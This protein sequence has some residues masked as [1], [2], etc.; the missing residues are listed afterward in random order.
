[1]V[2]AKPHH[3]IGLFPENSAIKENKNIQFRD[4]LPANNLTLFYT[5]LLCS[6]IFYLSK[7]CELTQHYLVPEP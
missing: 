4:F 2:R 7:T 5:S 1:M 6:N 3:T